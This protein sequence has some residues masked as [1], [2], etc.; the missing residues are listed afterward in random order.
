MVQ[1]S[2]PKKA[3]LRTHDYT[4]TECMVVGRLNVHSSFLSIH[5]GFF[6]DCISSYALTG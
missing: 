6:F 5:L 2:Q 1:E 3:G 4:V